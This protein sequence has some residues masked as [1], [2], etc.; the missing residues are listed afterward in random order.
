VIGDINWTVRFHVQ[1]ECGDITPMAANSTDELRPASMYPTQAKTRLEWGTQT[2]LA[3]RFVAE[4][5]PLLIQRLWNRSWWVA[6]RCR[7]TAR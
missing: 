4:F 1:G 6:E 5:R 3:G 7:V 2:S